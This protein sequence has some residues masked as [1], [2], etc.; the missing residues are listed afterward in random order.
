MNCI[1]QIENLGVQ[2]ACESRRS[3]V[4]RMLFIPR[5]DVQRINAISAASPTSYSDVVTI[6]SASMNDQAV[7]VKA[8]R[9]FAELVSLEGVGELS[10]SLNGSRG[11]RQLL[12]DLEIRRPEFRAKVLGFFA[13]T[14]NTEYIL[15]VQT[16]SGEW[17]LI[18]DLRRGAKISESSKATSGKAVTDANGLELH[19]TW[20]CIAPR[21]FYDGWDPDDPIRGVDRYGI[22][23]A[24]CTE[25]LECLTTE[26]DYVLLVE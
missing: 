24:I 21:V 8:G 17:H 22:T 26:D 9:D 11:A 14:L 13:T 16:E 1:S 3:G 23:Y 5:A 10:Y 19:F 6:G 20:R 15:I 2:G 12:A 25:D 4:F 7:E 18:G